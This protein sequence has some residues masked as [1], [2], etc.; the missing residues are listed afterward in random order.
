MS[1][2]VY[3]AAMAAAAYRQHSDVDVGAPTGMVNYARS[4][5]D[6]AAAAASTFC[7]VRDSTGLIGGPAAGRHCGPLYGYPAA[8]YGGAYDGGGRLCPGPG[9]VDAAGGTAAGYLPSCVGGDRELFVDRRPL[10][11]DPSLG[12]GIDEFIAPLCTQS[13]TSSS[14][15]IV[16]LNDFVCRGAGDRLTETADQAALEPSSG[17]RLLPLPDADSLKT[18]TPTSTRSSCLYSSDNITA[19]SKSTCSQDDIISSSAKISSGLDGTAASL[20]ANPS[21]TSTCEK[22]K[23]SSS[24][25]Q[26]R[27]NHITG[28]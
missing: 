6:A 21:V 24:G 8:T 18:E 3:A 19:V 25:N 9:F 15:A 22:A 14:A 11:H 27:N 5:H 13:S 4:C 7:G 2:R 17:G 1:C 26:H 10:H 12:G 20:P 16:E 23:T 28:P